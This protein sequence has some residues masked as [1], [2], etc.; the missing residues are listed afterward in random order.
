MLDVVIH[1]CNGTM[2]QVLTKAIKDFDGINIVAGV[3][4]FKDKIKNSY[5]VYESFNELKENVNVI[6]DFSHHSLV[7][8]MVKY[9]VKTKTPVIIATTGLSEDDI[10]E[11]EKASKI[12]PIFESA[13]MSLGINVLINLVKKA[14]NIL[15]ES[16]DIEII[17]KHHNKKLD[18]PSGTAF[19]IA[20][21]I[22]LELDNSKKYI[23]G[24]EG[25]SDKRDKNEIGIHAIRGGSI[26]GEHTVIFAGNDE[27][28]EVKHSAL[29][30]KIFAVGAIKAAKFIHNK[31][32]GL[33]SMK[34]MLN[35]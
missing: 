10:N 3:D 32:K 7:K 24:R 18:S 8:D 12:I 19:M 31:S 35:D 21:E 27:I 30:K 11:I 14:A 5:P 22:N 13:N 23:H 9:C 34:S 28:L 29:S 4:L 26:P 1:G 20:N 25:R 15:N 6:I 17:E 2:G 16:F 33:Y